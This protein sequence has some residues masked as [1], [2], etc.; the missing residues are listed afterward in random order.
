[1]RPL[2]SEGQT[3]FAA[4]FSLPI[5]HLNAFTSNFRD[6]AAR[7][8]LRPDWLHLYDLVLHSAPFYAQHRLHAPELPLGFN[9]WSVPLSVPSHYRSAIPSL[10]DHIEAALITPSREPS[11]DLFLRRP[12]LC[13]VFDALE[14]KAFGSKPG[15]VLAL[16]ESKARR[17]Q[18]AEF[19]QAALNSITLT[20][21]H[22]LNQHP[23]L[24]Q[25][26]YQ[27]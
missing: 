4:R 20:L 21:L 19:R 23:D 7:A 5:N 10:P 13:P 22:T 16:F 27:C 6:P 8:R 11:L 1:M 9:S 2:P 3:A 18:R 26:Y 17:T 15:P 12:H 25:F 14:I 24:A